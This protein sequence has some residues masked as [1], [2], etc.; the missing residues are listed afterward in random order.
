MNEIEGVPTIQILMSLSKATQQVFLDMEEFIDIHTNIIVYSPYPL[1]QVTR[2]KISKAYKELNAKDILK[3]VK[4]KT[5][6]VNPKMFIPAGG[7]Y[8]KVQEYWDSL[9]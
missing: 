8:L 2:N 6:L 9:P 7:N 3:R 4:Q 5:Y 1:T